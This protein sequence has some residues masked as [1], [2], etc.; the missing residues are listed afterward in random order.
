MPCLTMLI[1]G[2][3]NAQTSQAPS[4]PD[5]T[6]T[7]S[8]KNGRGHAEIKIK[9]QP[10][11]SLYYEVHTKDHFLSNWS[12]VYRVPP[13]YSQ[14]NDCPYVK[15]NSTS[16]YTIIKFSFLESDYAHPDYIPSNG[17]LDF[18]VQALIGKPYWIEPSSRLWFEDLHWTFN[19]AGP[20]NTSESDWSEIQTLS[21]ADGSVYPTKNPTS[22]PTSISSTTPTPPTP[23]PTS[24][25]PNIN[26]G[27]HMPE[28]EPFPTLL[29]VAVS[30]II[31]VVIVS[32]LLFR[33]HQK[34]AN[35]KQ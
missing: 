34:T 22:S 11:D 27:P 13:A 8:S 32:V 12:I 6:V 31:A 14:S 5:F 20:S 23:S 19:D 2:A 18:R 28:S 15:Q 26:T 17:Q 24:S 4:A 1:V 25:M 9:N 33:K 29:L 3:V 21:L 16:E 30:V 35:L 7:Y 10:I